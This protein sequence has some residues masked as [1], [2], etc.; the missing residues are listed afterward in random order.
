MWN[1]GARYVSPMAWPGSNG[2]NAGK[3]GY[4]PFTAWRETP[5]EEAAKDFLLARAHLPPGSKLWTFGAAGHADSDGWTAERGT[6]TSKP[7]HLAILPDANG[8]VTLL[9]ADRADDRRCGRL[10]G[11]PVDR[12]NVT[13]EVRL[14]GRAGGDAPWQPMGEGT[15]GEVALR[16]SGVKR[17]DQLKIDLRFRDS[18][19]VVLTRVGMVADTSVRQDTRKRPRLADVATVE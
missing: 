7:A 8:T 6:L 17:L 16:S 1:Y 14:W 2:R 4:D 9:S 18:G 3:P 12:G 10:A 13:V 15:S 5:L 11:R 19:P